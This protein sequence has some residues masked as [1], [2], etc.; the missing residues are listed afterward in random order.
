MIDP[1]LE[2]WKHT[3]IATS[4]S[5]VVPDGCRDLIVRSSRAQTPVWFITS[6]DDCARTVCTKAGDSLIGFRLKPGTSI[7]SMQLRKA[8]ATFTNDSDVIAAGIR[9]T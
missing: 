9:E 8:T 4:T 3:A 5:I 2:I 1:L 6:L 7:D